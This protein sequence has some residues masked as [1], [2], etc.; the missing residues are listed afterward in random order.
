MDLKNL[1]GKKIVILGFGKEGQSSLSLLKKFC[2]KNDFI[3]AD[4]M[5][6]NIFQKKF[7]K[8]AADKNLRFFLGK[9]YLNAVEEGDIIVKTPGIPLIK[10]KPFLKK[11]TKV[12]SQTEIFLANCPGITIGVTGTKGKSTTSSLIYKILKTGEKKV[13]LIGNIGKP[14][15]SFLP[16]AKPEDIFVYE[17]SC[18]QLAELKQ[19]PE[20]AV[21]LN[22]YPEHLDYYKNFSSYSKAKSN[23][24][25]W[26]NK[27]NYLIYNAE[28]KAISKI[29]KT[30]PAKKI[31]IDISEAKN[32]IGKEKTALMGNFNL[33]NIAAAIET[34]KIFKIPKEK[35]L[36]A[37]KKFKPLEHRLEKAGT[38]FGITFY[39][40]SLSTIEQSAIAALEA[41][42]PNVETIMLGGFDRGL[43][44]KNLAEKILE[45][46]LKN[47]ILFPETGQKIWDEVKKQTKGKTPPQAFFTNNM[48]DAIKIAYKNTSKRKICLMSCASTS[49]NLFRDYREK[50]ELFKKYAKE[51]NPAKKSA[52]KIL[53]QK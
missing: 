52:A 5:E 47:L 38:Y 13:R 2:R 33:F 42:G 24:A 26:Q 22:L 44:F 37:L 14:A 32:F 25:R 6:K 27:N 20:I 46:N 4:Q 17:M 19:S 35:T 39:N 15:L 43:T 28:D 18:H 29:A 21:F 53:C 31:K 16:K 11:G 36:E 8:L 9:N 30:S 7:S 1:A 3:I 34:A 51:F 12:A 45:S 50:G 40:D 48:A 23:I 10:I 41:L 49:F